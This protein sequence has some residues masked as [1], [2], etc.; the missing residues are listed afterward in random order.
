MH[1]A[2]GVG[3]VTIF[4]QVVVIQLGEVAVCGEQEA[5]IVGPVLTGVQVVVT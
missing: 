3:P 5:A 4:G 1:D 2:T